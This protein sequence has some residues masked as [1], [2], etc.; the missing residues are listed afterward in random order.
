MKRL[1]SQKTLAIRSPFLAPDSSVRQHSENVWVVHQVT[2]LGR[3]CQRTT[4]QRHFE[5]RARQLTIDALPIA[6]KPNPGPFHF[7]GKRQSRADSPRGS[8]R[9][10]QART[11]N[12]HVG[13]YAATVHRRHGR[14]TGN[15]RRLSRGHGTHQ[16]VRAARGQRLSPTRPTRRLLSPVRRSVDAQ[17]EAPGTGAPTTKDSAPRPTAPP[18]RAARPCSYRSAGTPSRSEE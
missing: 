5:L 15:P 10:F 2:D 13:Q 16:P 6:E 7:E 14:T 4:G 18:A 8:I 12:R 3:A 17:S 1:V 9:D 11:P